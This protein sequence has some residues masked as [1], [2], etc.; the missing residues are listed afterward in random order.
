VLDIRTV[1]SRVSEIAN[2]LLP[3]DALIMH[4]VDQDGNLIR[5]AVS[6]D[7]FPSPPAWAKVTLKTARRD[8]V[9]IQD[10]RTDAYPTNEPGEVRDHLIRAG[11]R[12]LLA[13]FTRARDQVM[14]VAFTSKRLNAFDQDDLPVA[15][16]IVDHI[17]LAVSHEQLA[18][19]AQQIAEARGRADRLEA[20][21]QMLSEELESKSHLRVVGQ[22][23]EWRD[24]LKKATQVAATDTTVLLTGESGTG[25][26]VVARFI[27]RASQR[28]KGP[29]VALNCAALPEQLLESEL[30]GYE[31]GAFTK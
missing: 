16:R 27:Y 10:L 28:S 24:V 12:S 5:Q 11:Y 22:S 13:V 9:I 21:V 2:K 15:H 6:T 18:E 25:K 29:F 3:H 30:F 7:D 26:E 1:F 23:V 14:I 20:R 4:F 8:A 17:A 19:A 31:R